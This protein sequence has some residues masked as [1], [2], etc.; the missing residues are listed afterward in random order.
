MTSTLNGGCFTLNVQIWQQGSVSSTAGIG[1]TLL[2]QVAS[3]LCAQT[4]KRYGG[5]IRPAVA[6]V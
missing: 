1:V 5:A 2:S 6:L 3:K 4:Y